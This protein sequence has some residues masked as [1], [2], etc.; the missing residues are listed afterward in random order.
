MIEIIPNYDLYGEPRIGSAATGFHIEDIEE[1]SKGLDWVIK[2][3]RHRNLFQI[4]CIFEGKA[5]VQIDSLRHVMKGCSLLSVPAGVVHAFNFQPGS[6]GVVI[7]LS[8]ENIATVL[9]QGDA[10]YLR[11]LIET[12]TVIDLNSKRI[13]Q[14]SQ[15]ISMLREEFLAH[16]DRK[17]SALLLLTKLLLITAKRQVDSQLIATAAIPQH[18]KTVE[19]FRDLVEKHYKEQWQVNRY[20]KE[21]NVSTSTL[22]RMCHKSLDTN[23]KAIIHDRVILEAKRRLT[24]TQQPL[25]QIAYHLGFKD[26]AYFSRLF[27]ISEN[28]SPRDF[29]KS[30]QA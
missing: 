27:K 10:D 21:L 25:D 6:E 23:A 24:Y 9:G 18:L 7:T 5:D 13:T 8:T 30:Q 29:R 19:R 1:R 16:A 28:I 11:P 15:C 2:P 3:H 17:L 12:A 4:L 22:N 20:A 26:P 14:L